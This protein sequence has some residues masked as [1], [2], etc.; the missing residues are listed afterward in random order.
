MALWGFSERDPRISLV[1]TKAKALSA[2]AGHFHHLSCKLYPIAF[3]QTSY[4]HSAYAL[5]RRTRTSRCSEGEHHLYVAALEHGIPYAKYLEIFNHVG[6]G[7]RCAIKP[8]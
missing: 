6:T 5:S 7:T 1:G 3:S 4:A 8:G 2:I